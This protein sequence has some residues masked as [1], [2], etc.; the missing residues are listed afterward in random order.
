M[1]AGAAALRSCFPAS[2]RRT[3]HRVSVGRR[4]G[5]PA[6][7]LRDG[8]AR[9][10]GCVCVTWPRPGW[11]EQRRARRTF[12]PGRTAWGAAPV[13]AAPPAAVPAAGQGPLLPSP[14]RRGALVVVVVPPSVP[15][16]LAAAGPGQMG[17]SDAA[18][19]LNFSEL[20][21]SGFFWVLTHYYCIVRT[22]RNLADGLGKIPGGNK[23]ISQV[24][25][26]HRTFSSGW[27]QA[28]WGTCRSGWDLV[29]DGMQGCLITGRGC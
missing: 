3:G 21:N 19:L 6:P 14:Q 24:G 7:L 8:E 12:L 27:A 17:R 18:R 5:L 11:R 13:P 2:R 20:K 29:I 10:G 26:L 16:R 23:T 4:W 28:S 9:G 25:S 22:L 15:A 1:A